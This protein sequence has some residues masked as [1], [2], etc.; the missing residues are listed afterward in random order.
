MN[1]TVYAVY[2]SGPDDYELAKSIEPTARVATSALHSGVVMRMEV[3]SWHDDENYRLLIDATTKAGRTL[4]RI[5][6]ALLEH[7]VGC[8]HFTVCP[9]FEGDA[10]RVSD[11][12]RCGCAG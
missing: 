12:K 3:F 9:A 8:E 7:E 6:T 4:L 5:F 2:F 11:W 10:R 1:T